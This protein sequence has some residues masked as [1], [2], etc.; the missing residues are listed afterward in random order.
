WSYARATSC[1]GASP[2]GLIPGKDR[3]ASNASEG[4]RAGEPAMRQ[5][6]KGKSRITVFA[7]LQYVR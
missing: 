7:L 2:G 4:N 1:S 5:A 3:A 6:R